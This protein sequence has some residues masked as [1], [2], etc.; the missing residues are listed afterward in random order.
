MKTK[1]ELEAQIS[2]ALVQFEIDYLGRGPK[3]ARSHVIEDKIG[4]AHV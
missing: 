4:R 1:G 2:E 3:E